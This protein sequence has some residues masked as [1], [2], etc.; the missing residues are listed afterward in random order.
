MLMYRLAV[1][2]RMPGTWWACLDDKPIME[3]MLG[4]KLGD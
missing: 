3:L 2:L 1:H 4:L